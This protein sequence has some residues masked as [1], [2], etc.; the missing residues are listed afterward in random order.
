[1]GIQSVGVSVQWAFGCDVACSDSS[2]F[3][4]AVQVAKTADVVIM[5]VGLDQGQER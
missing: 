5:V 1:M 2:G 3:A 4:E